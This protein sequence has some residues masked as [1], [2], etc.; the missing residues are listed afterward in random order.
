M[1]DA[2][3]WMLDSRSRKSGGFLLQ[4]RV[5]NDGIDLGVDFV[6]GATQRMGHMHA[7]K[8]PT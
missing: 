3:F 6:H 4:A 1:L 2:G 7:G 5:F 8:G